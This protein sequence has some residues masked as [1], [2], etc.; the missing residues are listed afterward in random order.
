MRHVAFGALVLVLAPARDVKA[1]GPDPT[2]AFI[3]S[4]IALE[5]RGRALASGT[6][7]E[8]HQALDNFRSAVRLRLQANDQIEAARNHGRIG[9]MYSYL[10]RHDSALV[11]YRHALTLQER[12]GDIVGLGRTR[13]NLALTLSDVGDTTGA[14]QE[15]RIALELAQRGG[16]ADDEAIVLHNLGLIILAEG[17]PDSAASLFRRMLLADP[18]DPVLKAKAHMRLASFHQ[19]RNQP[20]SV[21]RHYERALRLLENAGD[22]KVARTARQALL[23]LY[24]ERRSDDSL[25]A[26]IARNLSAETELEASAEALMKVLSRGLGRY[27]LGAQEA[28]RASVLLGQAYALMHVDPSFFQHSLATRIDQIHRV[29]PQLRFGLH[30]LRNALRERSSDD[31]RADVRGQWWRETPD[32]LQA[33]SMLLKGLGDHYYWKGWS[34]TAAAYYE[35][36]LARDNESATLRAI[37]LEA[38]IPLFDLYKAFGRMREVDS[39]IAVLDRRRATTTL[40]VALAVRLRDAYTTG[41]F[42]LMDS[43]QYDRA[44]EQYHKAL[45]LDSTFSPAVNNLGFAYVGA[46]QLDS[47]VM[48]F[49]RAVRLDPSEPTAT[50]NLGYL[51]FHLGYVDRALEYLA[52]SYRLRPTLLTAINIAV[53]FRFVGKADSAHRWDTEARH[54]TDTTAWDE[55]GYVGGAW[56]LNYKSLQAGDLK[57]TEEAIRVR[58]PAQKRAVA[59]FGLSVDEA[60]AGRLA[61]A[62][63]LFNEAYRLTSDSEFRCFFA[64]EAQ[65]LLNRVSLVPVARTWLTAKHQRLAQGARCP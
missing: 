8:R 55:Y 56:I 6:S 28:I 59:T 21:I 26:L 1:Q 36:A 62:E 15:Y 32:R 19:S 51:L 63:D 30:E 23:A 40:D 13:Q 4:A 16:D 58:T 27:R 50:N 48:L 65:A 2:R 53:A 22:V 34:R 38:A 31:T 42:Q 17:R 12:L 20:D 9:V 35:A 25:L 18:D 33:W 10:E 11:Y 64:N 29:H 43:L 57:T 24:Q 49:E 44:K 39:L 54:G 37:D 41:G 14:K 60:M 3:D 61:P 52:R 5:D 45:A 47:A 46:R 7:S